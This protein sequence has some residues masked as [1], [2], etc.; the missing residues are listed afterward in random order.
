MTVGFLDLYIFRHG[1]TDYYA[2]HRFQ[3][4]L[5]IPLNSVGREQASIL[6]EVLRG[7]GIEV[8]LS[9]PL[10]RAH[11][12]AT[13]VARS[14]KV[15]VEKHPE[16]REIHCGDAE[17]RV[18]AEIIE[19]FGDDFWHR[20]R[21]VNEPDLDLAFPGGESKRACGHR[22]RDFFAN[23][24][25]EANY[26]T[27]AIASPGLFMRY[28]VHAIIEFGADAEPIPIPN[29][30]AYQLRYHRQEKKWELLDFNKHLE[31]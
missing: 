4:G 10:S 26:S 17:G 3:G 31:K 30:A 28:A 6:A 20:W 25:R 29:C 15:D 22:A 23:L 12:T 13:I 14:L 19:R 21:S 2:E 7:K 11:E 16:L 1:E 18:R 27:V 9:S 8:I 5:D 24:A